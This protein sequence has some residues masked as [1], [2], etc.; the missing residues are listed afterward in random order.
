M[1]RCLKALM[2]CLSMFCAIPCPYREWDEDARPLTT[3]F[4]PLVGVVIGGL[5]TLA[6]YCLRLLHW[7]ALIGGAALCAVPFLL[8][9]G[10][11]LDGY[12]DVVDAVRS[13][14]N[15][16]ERRRILKDP[17]VGSFAVLFTVLFMMVQ[18]ALLASARDDS[19]IFSLI[20]IAVV[21]RCMAALFVTVLRPISESEY[22][23]AYRKGVKHSHIIVLLIQL[24]A[25]TA[26]GFIFLGKYGFTA[27]AVIAGCLLS[28]FRAY[29]S[30]DG[31]SGDIAGYA[32]VIGELCGIAVYA[33]L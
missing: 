26:C 30:L 6:A 10:I 23:G 24:A 31:M 28:V 17:H 18:F 20:L 2:M 4:L 19:N 9:G 8:T 3:L 13:C 7:P 29:R 11:H 25:A 33:L 5:W 15:P 32:L 27:L 14:R 16:D 22:A 12:M 1:K 21:S